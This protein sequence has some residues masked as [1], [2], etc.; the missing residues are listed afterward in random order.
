[1]R[2]RFRDND[3]AIVTGGTKGIG[4]AVVQQ[5]VS[6]GVP[7]AAIYHSDEKAAADCD[8]VLDDFGVETGIYQVDVSDF[9]EVEKGFA[10]IKDDLGQPSILVNNAGIMRNHFLRR[11]KPEDW[12]EVIQ[13]N[14]TG[15]FY[16][17]RIGARYMLRHSHGS[18]VNVSSVAAQKGFIGQA[19][20]AASKSGVLGFTRA[21]A[22]ELGN[23]SIRVNAVCPGYTDTQLYKEELAS[24]K[25]V[26]GSESKEVRENIPMNRIAD[27]EEIADV[28]VFLASDEASYVNGGI[29]RVDGGLLA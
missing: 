18:I 20:Y 12:D 21:A 29:L 3:V 28:I 16:C 24:R 8:S 19:N 27:S 7:T 26:A 22:R 10:E 15:I 13:T 14:L 23:D 9:N 5:L 17:T 25:R 2:S 1:M 11:L 6:E 4:R